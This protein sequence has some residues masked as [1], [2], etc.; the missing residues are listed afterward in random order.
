[1]YERYRKQQFYFEHSQK[2]FDFMYLNKAQRHHRDLLF[3]S[4]INKGLL[5]KSLYS[6]HHRGI[7]LD[8][9]YEMQQYRDS[10]PQYGADRDIFERPYNDSAWNIVSE[11]S[12]D[13]KF[14]TEKTWKPILAKQPFIV[15]GYSGILA[16][17]RQLGFNT[18][19][20]WID[21]SYDTLQ[22]LASRTKS[23]VGVCESVMK[24]DYENVYSKTT[25]AR[26][27]NHRLFFDGKKLSE[28]VTKDV[29]LLLE[30]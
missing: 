27:H 10:Y 25:D 9:K 23:I 16:D 21:E 15:H 30:F 11:T 8:Q 28:A 19:S 13:E 26:E 12:V 1:M 2:Y 24:Q 17:L 6:Y 18:F 4:L 29:N 5:D 22:D 20:D 14:I 7:A 3:D